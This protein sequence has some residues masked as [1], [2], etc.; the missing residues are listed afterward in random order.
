MKKNSLKRVFS[1]IALTAVA[2][3]ATS[4]AAFAEGTTVGDEYN[5]FTMDEI[6]NEATVKPELFVAID[7]QRGGKVYNLAEVAG[8][9]VNVT[10]NVKGA[11]DK[12]CSTGLHIYYDKRLE[13]PRNRV[14][15]LNVTGGE[16]Q[17][18]LTTKTPDE[19]PTAAEQDML[20]FFVTTAGDDDFGYDG[21][22]WQFDVKIPAD[23]QEGDVFPIDIIYKSN[24]N[25]EDLFVNKDRNREGKLMQAYVFTKG[26]YNPKENNTFA[27]S[28]EDLAK[29]KA[30]ADINKSMDGYIAIADAVT[31]TTTTTTTTTAAPTTTT[32]AAPTT[33]T[34]AGATTTTTAGATTTTTGKATT[35]TT[36][37][38]EP[39]KTGVAGAGVAV[40]GLAVALGTAFVLRKRED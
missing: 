38:T 6:L 5:G 21:V 29:V 33:T 14:G 17:E 27:A 30:L 20:G 26:I 28:A 10:I 18:L 34:T 37:K 13:I 9:T 32:T 19:D 35:T 15:R 25:A 8:Q 3:S 39:P 12:Y 16:A 4:M 24:P 2:A 11:A 23:A 40:A 31:T 1:A 7:G 22:F 36:G